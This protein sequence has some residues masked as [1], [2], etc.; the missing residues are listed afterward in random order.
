MGWTNREAHR[1]EDPLELTLERALEQAE[2]W[3]ATPRRLHPA[4]AVRG[5][6][7]TGKTELLRQ[8]SERTPGAVY[9][10]CQG[11]EAADVARS[12]LQAWGVAHDGRSLAAAARAITQDRVALLA[13]VHWAD[14]F[15]TSTEPSRIT[16]GMVGHF[17]RSA[18]PTVRFVIERAAAGP[19]I[20]LPSRNELVLRSP[21]DTQAEEAEFQTLLTAHPALWG[22][23]ASELRDTPLAVW[24]VLCRTLGVA[25]S[26]RGLEGLAER[27]PDLLTVS[28]DATREVTVGFRAESLRHR[29]RELRPVDH[30]AIVTALVRSLDRTG[31]GAWS[32]AGPVRAYAAR[33]LGLHA[34]H[35]GLLDEVLGNGAVLANLDPTGLLR[36]LAARWPDGIPQG[37]IALDL[38]YLERLGLNSAPQEEWVSWLHHC[39]LS[40]GEEGL[41]E[42]VAREA[43]AR[44]PWRTVWSNCRPFGMFGRF[45][46]SGVG[47]SG[48]PSSVELTAENIAQQGAESG[49]WPLPETGFPVRHVFNSSRDDFSFLRAKRLESGHWLLVGASGNFA[50]SVQD[51]AEL[52]SPLPPA[53]DSFLEDPI[54]KASVWDCP[55]TALA[56]GAPSREWLEATFG[57][58]TCRRLREDDLP[59]GLVHAGS[60]EFLMET[61][62]PAL[63][64][65][66]PFVSTIDV[67]A[68]GLDPVPWP[69]DAIPPEV[70]GPF[71]RVGDW[72][73]GNVLLDGR[74]G[75]VVQDGSTG[76][77]RVIMASSLR[78][79]F[80]LL[81][82]CHEFLVS[83]FATNYERGDALVSLREWAEAIDPIT[84]T[85]AAWEYALDTDLNRWVAM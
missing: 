48:Y 79:F 16:Q 66:L 18:R 69:E 23:A 19:W 28:S 9:L 45:G 41:A 76:E 30:G 14:S 8:L 21:V 73:G 47:A 63:P 29:I 74:T 2:S 62:L 85:S 44:L 3:L 43:G 5:A 51:G 13:N 27:L 57:R 17:R 68:T 59:A 65:H 53:P 71:Y 36:A 82:L 60:R 77:D 70:A 83:D 54:T 78:Q 80:I 42:A 75:T 34:V 37:G 7:G 11:L 49:T 35:A 4:L 10:D 25:S 22:L 39:A 12:L 81:R 61:G 1:I 84:E 40:R 26:H 50:V 31:T 38:H 55:A 33:T 72:T 64:D 20:F 56:Q 58:G 32:M 24:S 67:A 52:E 6:A 15:V 46:K